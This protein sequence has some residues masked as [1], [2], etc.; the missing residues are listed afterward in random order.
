MY[1]EQLAIMLFMAV[2]QAAS[3]QAQIPPS[4]ISLDAR[5]AM[6]RAVKEPELMAALSLRAKRSGM[7]NLTA[8]G[9]QTMLASMY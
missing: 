5:H 7:R 9:R 6:I 1:S 4:P 3:P 2:A 8:I